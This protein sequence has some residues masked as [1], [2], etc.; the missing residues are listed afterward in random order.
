LGG[1]NVQLSAAG[2]GTLTEG[3]NTI[4]YT[5]I[6][7]TTTV[8]DGSGIAMP[9]AG[10]TTTVLPTGGIINE[11]GTWAYTFSNATVYPA[12]TYAGAIT[13]TATHTP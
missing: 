7:A 3:V 12:G 4:P 8:S 13:Y 2:V 10:A 6:G 5:T 9:A 11:A 1:A